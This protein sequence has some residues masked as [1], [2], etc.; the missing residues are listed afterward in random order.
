MLAVRDGVQQPQ[1]AIDK[2]TSDA[3]LRDII[4]R[5]MTANRHVVVGQRIGL[6]GC[7]ADSENTT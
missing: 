6:C 7:L 3:N 4:T 1:L 2:V 5:A